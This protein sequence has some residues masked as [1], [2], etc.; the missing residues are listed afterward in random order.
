MAAARAPPVR[1][2]RPSPDLVPILTRAG[3]VGPMCQAKP[4]QPCT[5]LAGT[6][7]ATVHYAREHAEENR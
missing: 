5:T 2:R 3:L 1:V 7:R 6:P 4:G